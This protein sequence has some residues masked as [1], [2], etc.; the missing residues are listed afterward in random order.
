MFQKKEVGINGHTSNFSW[1]PFTLQK[2]Y[3]QKIKTPQ[4]LLIRLKMPYPFP[5]LQSQQQCK[6]LW[7]AAKREKQ[8]K[9]R[10]H[11]LSGLQM[12]ESHQQEVHWMTNQ[13]S[14]CRGVSPKSPR[15]SAVII[16]HTLR[17][18]SHGAVLQKCLLCLHSLAWLHWLRL[19]PWRMCTEVRGQLNSPMMDSQKKCRRL[20]YLFLALTSDA[21]FNCKTLCFTFYPSL[22]FTRDASESMWWEVQTADKGLLPH[23]AQNH[24]KQNLAFWAHLLFQKPQFLR[25]VFLCDTEQKQRDP[26]L[27]FVWRKAFDGDQ[28]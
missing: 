4:S 19:Q 6:N 22:V 11:T 20:L 8:G 5:T 28:W 16:A 14:S 18:R 15:H 10:S 24:L 27:C 26:H 12:A 3:F 7:W 17:L 1:M 2:P 21:P 9:P 25:A 23:T 13:R